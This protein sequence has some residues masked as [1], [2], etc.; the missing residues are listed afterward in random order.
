MTCYIRFEKISKPTVAKRISMRFT[1]PKLDTFKLTKEIEIPYLIIETYAGE[2]STGL[3][4]RIIKGAKLLKEAGADTAV[5]SEDKYEGFFEGSGITPYTGGASYM[6][7]H[8]DKIIRCA[9]KRHGLIPASSTCV[10]HDITGAHLSY[11]L[12]HTVSGLCRHICIISDNEEAADTC[13]DEYTEETGTP[14]LIGSGGIL[15]RCD[16]L[17]SFGGISRLSECNIPRRALIIDLSCEENKN[18]VLN[19]VVYGFVPY[20]G[21][22]EGVASGLS[23][24]RLFSSEG[25][26][27]FEIKSLIFS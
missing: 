10:I 8:A 27:D 25:V 15:S 19:R 1:K 12:L 14:I 23:L 21:G 18:A 20:A 22:E 7:R 4:R 16:M 24:M 6:R 17:V 11:E 3:L 5:L 9:A 26:E 2:N 13:A